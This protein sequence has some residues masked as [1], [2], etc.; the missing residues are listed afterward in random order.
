MLATV[1][2]SSEILVYRVTRNDLGKIAVQPDV[3]HSTYLNM[4]GGAKDI[5]NACSNV[6][7][8]QSRALFQIF[9]RN[10][11]C[12]HQS[13]TETLQHEEC[14]KQYCTGYV[15][16]LACTENLV[17]LTVTRILDFCLTS[18]WRS[19]SVRAVTACFVAQYMPKSWMGGT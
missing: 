2:F 12:L 6:F 5:Q 1:S 3:T 10:R 17:L 18:S 4:L 16:S 13:R 9:F 19:P 15:R 11:F 14:W 7:W 8:F